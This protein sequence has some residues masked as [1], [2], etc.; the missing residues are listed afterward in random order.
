MS[1]F[2][3][4]NTVEE[5]VAASQDRT[6]RYLILRNDLENVPSI[7]LMPFQSLNGE[8]DGRKIV[9]KSGVD[10]FCLSKGNELKNL[11]IEASPDKR[12]IYQDPEMES[13]NTHHLTRISVTGQISF[14]VDNRT[15]KGR[16]EASFVHVKNA[17]MIHLTDCPNRFSVDMMQGAFTVWN[18]SEDNTEIE[19]DITHFSCGGE[20]NPIKG[21]GLV[22]CGTEQRMGSV[23]VNILSCGHIYT[24]GEIGKGVA[25]LVAAGIGICYR[26]LVKHMDVYG[27]ITCYGGNEMGLYNWGVI[28]HATI[29]DRIE[30]H[31]A[32]GC[33]FI[34]AGNTGKIN[35]MH[36]IETFGTGARG[37][38]MFNGA[39]KDIHFDR[40]VTHGDAASA[41]QFDRYIDRISI[42]RGIEVFGN[43]MNVL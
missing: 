11:M 13:L 18:K 6:A 24:K 20:T 7:N 2:R 17:S 42:S 5:L 3:I 21:S 28:E 8:F 22:L 19:V 36:E 9:F 35:F 16:I 15:K 37:F 34:N 33:G 41:I 43:A 25:N 31:G 30:T 10:G 27:R 26:T 14:I 4:I 12:A 40:I 1:V 29:T 32:N 38:Y 23:L 39:A